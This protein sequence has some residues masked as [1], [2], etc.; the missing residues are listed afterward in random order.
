MDIVGIYHSI[1]LQQNIIKSWRKKSSHLFKI[2]LYFTFSKY[3]WLFKK[4][5]KISA[6]FFRKTARDH[7][8]LW[9]HVP[10][11]LRY[12]FLVYLHYTK[13]ENKYFKTTLDMMKQYSI[14]KRVVWLLKLLEGRVEIIKKSLRQTQGYIHTVSS[15][16]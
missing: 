16:L 11:A 12:I 7:L 2:T 9:A 4:Q 8:C 14:F 5:L 10:F 1:L 15:Q 3:L 6:I 13:F